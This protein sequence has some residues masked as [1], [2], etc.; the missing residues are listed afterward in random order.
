[1][2]AV[3]RQWSRA[4]YD[5]MVDAGLLHE[6]EHVQLI[7]GA[8]LQMP[9]HRPAHAVSVTLA[10][11]E[12]TRVFCDDPIG[13]RVQLP[14]ALGDDSEP[15]P[16]LAVVPGHARDFMVDHPTTAVLVVEVADSSLAFDRRK[17]RIYAA[18]GIPEYWIVNLAEGVLE[19]NRAPGAEAGSG[20]FAYAERTTL[21]VHGRLSPLARPD[22][23][24]AVA[25][26]LP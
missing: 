1:M 26:L 12:L 17:A 8:I 2:S 9:A 4:E 24:V 16:D 25:D 13:I 3:A 7:E 10:L 5:Q 14:L 21:D 22:A 23:S 18:A 11:H 20:C 6:D 15:E 19:V